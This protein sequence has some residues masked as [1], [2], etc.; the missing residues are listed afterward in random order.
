MLIKIKE[1]KELVKR[2]LLTEYSEEEAL[3]IEDVL[4][5]GELSGRSSHG[6]LRLI[7]GNYGVF[8]DK[9][10]FT[11][12]FDRKTKVSTLIRGNNN[13]GMLI[14]PLAMQEGIKLAKRNSIG[15][16]GTMGSFNSI[17]PLSYYCEKI[18]KENLIG[19]IM[20]SAAPQIAPFNLK[21]PFFGTNPIAFVIPADPLPVIFD[22]STSSMTFGDIVKYKIEVRRL[23]PHAALDKNGEETT[24][25]EEALKGATLAFDAFYKGSGLAMM[26]E[27]LAAVWSGGGFASL[28]EEKGWGNLF[29]M[30]SPELLSDVKTLKSRTHELITHLKNSS[31]RDGKPVRIPGERSLQTKEENLRRGEIEV[32][33][34]IVIELRDSLKQKNK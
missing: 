3:L 22:M 7:R 15:I 25:P 27:I 34:E 8:V 30:M 29:M 28:H 9:T 33:E 5:Y 12:H 17:G 10:R 20:A 11:P 21:Q 23:K 26:V 14:G 13:P 16:V 6:L 18:G 4:M 19:I 32:N 31:T 24:D 2:V 1:L